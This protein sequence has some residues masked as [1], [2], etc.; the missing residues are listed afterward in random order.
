LLEDD[1]NKIDD[2]QLESLEKLVDRDDIELV[3]SKKLLEEVS[4]TKDDRRKRNLEFYLRL[5]Q[6]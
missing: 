1:R 3:T 4:A 2:D 5:F 6:R